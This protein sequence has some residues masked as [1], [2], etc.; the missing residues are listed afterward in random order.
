V[1]QTGD[2]NFTLEASNSLRRFTFESR[3]LTNSGQSNFTLAFTPENVSSPHYRSI[4]ISSSGRVTT[5]QYA[6]VSAC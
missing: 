2:S 1:R 3:G 4:C 6:G 5:K